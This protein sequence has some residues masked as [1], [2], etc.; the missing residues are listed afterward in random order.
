MDDVIQKELET[1]TKMVLNWKKNYAQWAPP[2]GGGEYLAQEL[3]EEISKHVSPFV[4][5]L[6]ACNHITST[7]AHEFLEFCYS[8]VEDLRNSL[9]EAKT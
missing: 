2:E 9:S 5:R 8:Q 4:Q 6:F 7:E 1:I 3:S